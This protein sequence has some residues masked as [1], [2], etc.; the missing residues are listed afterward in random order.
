MNERTVYRHFAN[1]HEL[2]EAVLARLTEGAGVDLDGMAL[3]DIRSVT[4]R[5]FDYVSTFP[6][7]PRTPRD[8]TLAAAGQRLQEAL[9]ATVAPHTQD[10]PEADRTAAAAM[11]DVLWSVATY[12][13]LVAGWQLDPQEA[14]RGV[15]WVIGLVEEAIRDGH[16][17]PSP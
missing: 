16:R 8:P 2:R 6:L 4:A 17:P 14:I 15:S 12:E 3:G 1:E 7:E 13:R 11:L 5:I 10:W 9:R